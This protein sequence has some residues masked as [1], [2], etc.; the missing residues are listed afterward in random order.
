MI[1]IRDSIPSR[2]RPYISWVL[3]ASCIVVFLSMKFLMDLQQQHFILYFY[4]MVPLRYY[5]PQWAVNFGF[6]R[7]YGLSFLSGLFLHG[8][9]LHLIINSWFIWIFAKNIEDSM[10]H[11]KFLA[12]YLACG[13]ISMLTQ[14]F[15][16]SELAIPVV[17][18]SG[19]IAGVLGAYFF[20][21]PYARVVVWI[22][23]LLLP[24]FVEIP[25]IAF[26]GFWMILQIQEATTSIFFEGE[27]SGVAWWAH[28]SGFVA[29]AVLYRLFL[30][31][32]FVQPSYE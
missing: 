10:G 29:G 25:A 5:D 32:D 23:I 22:P 16:S 2:T 31:D 11:W 18:A 17:G 3:M 8:G 21:F 30:R 13:V 15:F 24:I 12:F 9:W 4:G 1:P 14:W 20:L 27:S 19:A 6:P 7:D 26:L 28:I